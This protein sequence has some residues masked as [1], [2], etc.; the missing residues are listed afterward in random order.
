MFDV[1]CEYKIFIGA[2]VYRG[3]T[4]FAQ[5][6]SVVPEDPPKKKKSKSEIVPEPV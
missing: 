6:C 5:S 4:V 1:Y 2:I 3:V